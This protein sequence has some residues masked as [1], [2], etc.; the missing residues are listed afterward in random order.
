M[1]GDIDVLLSYELVKLFSEGLYKSSNKAVEELV[2][3]SFDAGAKNV[4]V[5]LPPDLRAPGAT[6]AVVDDGEG[7][8]QE[9][10]RR[11]WHIGK[12][13]KRKLQ[14]PPMGRKQ[15]GKF[16][17][18]KMS[19]YVLANRL[20]HISKRGDNYYSTSI[21]YNKINGLTDSVTPR[22]P[23]RIPLR[24]LTIKESKRAVES[25]AKPMLFDAGKVPLFGENSPESW[26]ISVMSDLKPKAYGIEP[27][28][29]R[30]ILRTAMP[31]RPDFAIWL[32]G[33]KLESSKV[34]MRPFKKWIIGKDIK[35]LP[36]PGPSNVSVS[37]KRKLPKS[38]EHRFGLC[39]P[40]LGR[41]TGYVEAY[42]DSLTGSKSDN[43]GRSHG[44]FVRVRDR[45]LNQDDDHFGISSSELRHGTFSRFRLVIHMDELDDGLRS[46][47]E[48]VSEGRQLEIARN[49]LRAIFNN[50]RRAVEM[51]DSKE[52]PGAKL[53]RRLATSPA[54]LSR[55]PIVE[56]TR[57]VAER[58]KKSRYLAV[59]S[60]ATADE[61]ELFLADLVQRAQKA[62]KFLTGK[63]LDFDGA[64]R[65]GIVKFDT[66]SGVLRLNGLHPFVATFDDEFANKRTG[67]PL[68]LFAMAEV[69]VEA[70]LHSIG[71]NPESV[72]DFLLTRDQ[73]L[74]DLASESGRQSASSVANE[75]SD[76]RNNPDK[77]EECV[78]KAFDVLGFD[79][80]R[81]GKSNEPDGVAVAI[82]P[83]DSKGNPRRYKV[84]LEAKSKEDLEGKVNAHDVDISA[85]IMHRNKYDCDHAIVVG[86]RFTT[87]GGKNSALWKSIDYDRQKTVETE[88]PRSI[89]LIEVDDLVKLVRLRPE[90][91][92]R[93]QKIRKLFKCILPDE[94]RKWVESIHDIHVDS[95][96]YREII[97]T[98]W[99]LQKNRSERMSVKYASLHSELY[100][101]EPPI[102]FDTDDDVKEM[103]TSLSLMAPCSVR[104]LEDRVELEQ[105]VDNTIK[106]I[107]DYG[108]GIV[109]D[110]R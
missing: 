8:D 36:R 22:E 1:T 5:V 21:D 90:K 93:L 105:S 74:R 101:L 28:R 6:I 62:E 97:E 40:E 34:N 73:L 39:I 46:T 20:T 52:E 26:T 24:E 83:P 110:C 29:L 58:K 107:A 15:I 102:K 109:H 94:S 59:P 49:V 60:H 78:C 72:D 42:R 86:P 87:S 80:R 96:R 35:E 16:G 38:S 63:E 84:S 69:L 2:T 10:L 99:E 66:A 92:L 77:F 76:A 79:T 64:S 30:W 13:N 14:S 98:I 88:K 44:F 67:Q 23:I 19:T 81:I 37:E 103:C 43:I 55:E 56:L 108:Q 70:H 11:H 51:H 68:E 3:N 106:E 75:L 41:V 4:H 9:G 32:N 33:E 104:A 12:S 71:I 82:L 53:A 61:R 17:I 95:S 27:G 48:S 85:V 50:T 57:A 91:R 89:T 100:H 25:W 7:M 45:L 31:L 18:G 47:R 54:G 65:D